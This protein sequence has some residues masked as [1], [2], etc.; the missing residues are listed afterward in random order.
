MPATHPSP[1]PSRRTTTPRP[2]ADVARA[3]TAGGDLDTLIDKARED[4][5]RAAKSLDFL[6]A[7]KFQRPHVRIAE[8]TRGEPEIACRR[9][10]RRIRSESRPYLGPGIEFSG[11]VRCRPCPY[12]AAAWRKVKYLAARKLYT[13]VMQEASICEGVAQIAQTSTKN[14]RKT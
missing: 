3:Y 9:L 7:A 12:S 4:M 11:S 5:E 2:A 1:I 13:V 10:S 6:A 14:F 8:V